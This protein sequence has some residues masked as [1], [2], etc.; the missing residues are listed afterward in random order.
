LYSLADVF[1][2]PSIFEGF[3]IPVLEAL[4]SGTPVITGNNS[5]LREIAGPGAT[6][7]NS[8]SAA[9]IKKA[10]EAF[11][12]DEKL[13]QTAIERG[14][15]FAEQFKDSVLAKQWLRTYQNALGA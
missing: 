12:N 8:A 2:Y 15:N 9:D 5:A 13:R 3:G 1:I 7:V 11:W 4:A 14:T 10:L 6:L